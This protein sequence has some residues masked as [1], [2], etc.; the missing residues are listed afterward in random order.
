MLHIKYLF[1]YITIWISGVSLLAISGNADRNDRLPTNVRP[2]LYA[3]SLVINDERSIFMG[4]VSIELRVLS[5]TDKIRLHAK[6]ISVNWRDAFLRNNAN[7]AFAL[8]NMTQGKNDIFELKFNESLAIGDYQLQLSFFNQIRS[9][10]EGL[11]IYSNGQDN[12][13]KK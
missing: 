7:Q 10:L 4:N 8:S 2:Q 11:Y 13:N 3:L 12:P 5:V 1:F 6:G 9:K